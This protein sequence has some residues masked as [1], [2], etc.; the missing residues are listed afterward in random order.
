MNADSFNMPIIISVYIWPFFF[1]FQFLWCLR[2][3]FKDLRWLCRD[4]GHHLLLFPP[5]SRMS[6]QSESLAQLPSFASLSHVHMPWWGCHLLWHF[7]GQFR[8][9]PLASFQVTRTKSCTLTWSAFKWVLNQSCLSPRS[10]R[11]LPNRKDENLS[12]FQWEYP[13]RHAAKMGAG[14]LENWEKSCC[15][16]SG[17]VIGTPLGQAYFHLCVHV[18]VWGGGAG[19][20]KKD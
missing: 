8:A 4:A 14:S 1:F 5:C 3:S 17:L 13:R 20:K 16:I 6:H 11:T 15:H 12:V 19:K 9:S 10:M 7:L 18:C 2:T